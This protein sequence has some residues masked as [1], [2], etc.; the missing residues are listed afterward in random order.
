VAVEATPNRCDADP[1]AEDEGC[2]LVSMLLVK[3]RDAIDFS[4]G[5][6]MNTPT[7]SASC[8]CFTATPIEGYPRGGE[9]IGRVS[10]RSGT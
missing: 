10:P 8:R 7:W 4:S 9:F 1:G 5:C 2:A 3:L 6:S